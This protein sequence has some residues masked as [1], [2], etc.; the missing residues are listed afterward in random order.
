MTA[1]SDAPSRLRD[2]LNRA[3]SAGRDRLTLVIILGI[4]LAGVLA[5]F[6]YLILRRR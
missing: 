6:V 3:V 4:V 5:L 1:V 2:T